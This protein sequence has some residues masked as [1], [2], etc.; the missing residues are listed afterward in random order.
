MARRSHVLLLGDSRMRIMAFALY[1]MLGGEGLW[2][3]E[4][5]DCCK[6]LV[7]CACA[8][9]MLSLRVRCVCSGLASRSLVASSL[10]ATALRRDSY[11][12]AFRW[13]C[14]RR[15]SAAAVSA[16]ACVRRRTAAN[17]Y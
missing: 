13:R 3:R 6:A 15:R 17:R 8:L 5:L 10:V 11:C 14:P 4:Q 7:C 2:S 12:D 16:G 1:K 9:C